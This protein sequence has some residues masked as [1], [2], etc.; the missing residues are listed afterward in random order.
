[1]GKYSVSP[2]TIPRIA[3]FHQVSRSFVDDAA[4][5]AIADAAA[6]R[7]ATSAATVTT[8]NAATRARRAGRNAEGAGSAGTISP[9][10]AEPNRLTL[11]P[12]GAGGSARP[13]V[14]TG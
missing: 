1:M 13:Y 7:A 8:A 5:W 12:V 11:A 14:P 10:M 4:S 9:R 2:S 6:G 3:A